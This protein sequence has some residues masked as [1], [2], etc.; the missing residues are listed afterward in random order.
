MCYAIP[1]KVTAIDGK[2]VIV[3]YFGEKRPAIAMDCGVEAG[4]YV[5]AQ[6]GI[7]VGKV[8]GDEALEILRIW[9]ERFF[10]LKRL[11]VGMS[12]G[13]ASPSGILEPI[14]K[15]A[16]SSGTLTKGEMLAVLGAEEGLDALYSSANRIRRERIDNACCVH[17]IIEFSNHCVNNCLYCGIRCG[18]KGIC[19]YRMSGE[20]ILDAVDEAVSKHGFKALVLQSGEDM[21][22]SDEDLVYIVK[23]IRERHSILLFMSVGERSLDCYRRLYEAGAYGA[24]LRFETSNAELYSKLRPGRKLEDRLSLI[25]GLKELGFVLATGFMFGLPGESRKDVVG[26]I[27]LTKSLGPDM[28]SFGP[29]IPHPA[30]PLSSSVGATLDDALK[31]IA[32]TRLVDH[33][34]KI[35]VTTAL[36]TLSPEAKR[37]GL[38]A[39]GNSLMID[40]TPQ[41]YRASYDLYPGKA[42]SERIG[43]TIVSTISLLQSLG[44]A[45]TD[46]GL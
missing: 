29:F 11:D 24:L 44:R 9:E 41:R 46:L 40:M 23:R 39:G 4:E 15:K 13:S 18:N 32:L 22:Y 8:P 27:L 37:E 28:H 35:L 20:Q 1:G 5:Y 30:T 10:D 38:L 21:A 31:A 14:L 33:E 26:N 42:S 6:G 2:R 34:A 16:E 43:D 45:P 25:R 36:E 12:A 17:G 19:R 3:E 7:V